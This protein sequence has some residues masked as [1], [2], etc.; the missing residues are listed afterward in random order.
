MKVTWATLQEVAV[1]QAPWAHSAV[2]IALE[3]PLVEWFKQKKIDVIQSQSL[4]SLRVYW[5]KPL[6]SQSKDFQWM[7]VHLYQE[8]PRDVER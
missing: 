3:C 4:A 6:G 2:C 7:T 8:Q 1:T 5:T